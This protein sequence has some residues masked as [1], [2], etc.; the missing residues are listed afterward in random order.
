MRKKIG[1]HIIFWTFIA[2]YDFDYLIDLYDFKR[3]LLYCLFE[4]TIYISEF[5][6]NLFLLLPLVLKSGKRFRYFLCILLLL[7]FLFFLYYIT[8]LNKPLLSVEITRGISS[9]LLNHSLYILMSYFVWYFY[10]FE[11]ET[12]KRLQL[13][14][15]KLQSEMMLLK[16]QISPHFL[17]NAL[18]NIYA[19]TLIKSD[20]AP[21]M[22]SALSDILRYF[23]YESNK[24]N[25]FLDS[26]LEMISK[27][28]LIQKYR[29]IPG[30]HNISFN[31]SGKSSGLKVP[32]LVFMTLIENAFKHGDIL[33]DENGYV[34][35]RFNITE[36]RIEFEIINSFSPKEKNSGL[37]LKNVKSQLEILYGKNY[38]MYINEENNIFNVTLGFKY[39]N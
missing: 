19:L 29:Q 36:T 34:D 31:V 11:L 27:Y 20:N 22:L 39:E 1:Y 23:L 33:E 16:S 25:V 13:E 2:L 21:K 5:Y 26:E 15:E 17:F 7:S 9:F 12:Q 14:N 8:G 28:I 4:V 38:E 10:K 35:I 6:I 3:A 37:G 32:P 24:K 18:N 30:M